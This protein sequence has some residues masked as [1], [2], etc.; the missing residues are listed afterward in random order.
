MGRW[1]THTTW[2]W[3]ASRRS[4]SPTACGDRAADA[5]IYF[6]EE[7]NVNAVLGFQRAS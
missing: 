6:V 1:V 3:R 5:G 4:R 2:R 7:Q